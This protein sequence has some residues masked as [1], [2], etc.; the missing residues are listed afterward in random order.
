MVCMKTFTLL[1]FKAHTYELCS[2]FLVLVEELPSISR[3]LIRCVYNAR[4]AFVMAIT[5]PDLGLYRYGVIKDI[6]S[7][8]WYSICKLCLRALAFGCNAITS[9]QQLGSYIPYLSG[10]FN[11]R[12]ITETYNVARVITVCD[13]E[14]CHNRKPSKMIIYREP[15]CYKREEKG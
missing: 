13:W 11:V 12:V 4:V 1:C 15:V 7:Y 6:L 10:N 9:T 3:Y 14:V 5:W 2:R 8:I